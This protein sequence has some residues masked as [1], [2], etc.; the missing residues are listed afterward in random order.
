MNN[1]TFYVGWDGNAGSAAWR[2]WETSP[3]SIIAQYSKA[4]IMNEY[5]GLDKGWN[6]PDMLVVGM[7][8]I[9]E[10]MSRTH[11]TMWC[12][13]NSPLMLGLDLR[14][15]EK[16]DEIY[17]IIVNEDAIAINWDSL[18]VQAKRIYCSLTDNP[19]IDY[20]TNTA[21]T[22]ILAKP[23]E[24]GD[25]AVSFI[26]V[27]NAPDAQKRSIDVDTIIDYIGSKM[28][29]AEKFKNADIYQIKD[30]WSKEISY[31]TEEIFSVDGLDACA[32]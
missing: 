31:T 25:V 26:N 2:S 9:N 14:R 5:A 12:M 21:R 18:G 15:V 28:T 24:N 17:N 3:N 27:N 19:D 7:G 16:G 11:M 22:D 6:D 1:I 13:M 23:L 4:V 30:I 8:G 32:T 29:N 20:I 10:T